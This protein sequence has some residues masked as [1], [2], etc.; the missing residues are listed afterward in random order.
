MVIKAKSINKVDDVVLE[1]EGRVY[2][3]SKI[4]RYGHPQQYD[5]K[6]GIWIEIDKSFPDSITLSDLVDKN[7]KIKVVHVGENCRIDDSSE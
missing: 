6:W 3:F 7:V 5:D 1:I 2:S 4:G